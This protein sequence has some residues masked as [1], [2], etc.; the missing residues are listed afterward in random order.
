MRVSPL[1]ISLW[2][3]TV[4]SNVAAQTSTCAAV[5]G[6]MVHCDHL[7]GGW[8]DCTSTGA[9]AT[10]Q[11]MGTE[12][13]DHTRGDSGKALGEGLGSLIA[14]MR[15]KAF[16]K[17]I[18][19]MLAAGDC[20]T[21]AKYAF[22]KGRLELGYAISQNCEALAN[23]IAAPLNEAP[24]STLEDTLRTIASQAKTPV[25]FD[26]NSTIT[27]VSAEGRQLVFSVVVKDRTLFTEAWRQSVVR[28][29][30][31][32]QG[33]GQFV[34]RGATIRADFDASGG[35]RIGTLTVNS[36]LCR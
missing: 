27:K 19:S 36:S 3:T 22:E 25:E 17:K 30:C 7:G 24:V 2:L 14:S 16:R 5:G 13:Y 18:G 23:R 21:A 33:V 12:G 34:R 32:P 1:L 9:V 20:E 8:T 26:E 15:E 6:N 29:V 11:T 35:T 31:D 28:E 4:G 10:C